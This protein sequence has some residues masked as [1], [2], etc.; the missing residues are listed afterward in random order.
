M[1]EQEELLDHIEQEIKPPRNGK[2][3]T[4]TEAKEKGKTLFI[5]VNCF[6]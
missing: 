1:A 6:N 3:K 5:F 2:K 4:N